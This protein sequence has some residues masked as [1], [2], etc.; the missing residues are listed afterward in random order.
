MASSKSFKGVVAV[1]CLMAVTACGTTPKA[2]DSQAVDA[3]ATRDYQA[4]FG[5]LPPQGETISLPEA[6]ARA[7]KYNLDNR[8]A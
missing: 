7:I 4:L 1:A 5:N 6:I 2:I 8:L 3:R